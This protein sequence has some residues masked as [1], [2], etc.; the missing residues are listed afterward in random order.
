[1]LIISA[2]VR[3]VLFVVVVVVG[4]SESRWFNPAACRHIT[5][6]QIEAEFFPDRS[7][8]LEGWI[9]R[10]VGSAEQLR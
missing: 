7:P 8:I 10:L 4:L 2:Q 9:D 3:V 6:Q 1:M 5:V